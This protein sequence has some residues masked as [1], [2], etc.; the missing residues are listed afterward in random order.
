MLK[1]I[2]TLV[3]FWSKPR[4]SLAINYSALALERA[5][6]LLASVDSGGIP[7]SPMIVNGI[8]RNLG[9]EVAATDPMSKTIER[10]RHFIG[11]QT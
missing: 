8:A 10:I 3:G 4:L 7:L 9:L 11:I 1:Q 6:D 5:Q 2:L